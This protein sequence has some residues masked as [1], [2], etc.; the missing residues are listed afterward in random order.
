MLEAGGVK[1]GPY[2]TGSVYQGDCLELMKAIPDGSIP[3]IWTDPPYGMNQND[4]DL[5]NRRE[6]AF[7]GQTLAKH[8]ESDCARP[9][10]N[11]GAEDMERVIRGMLTEAGRVLNRDCCC[12]CCCCSGGGG[13]T[14]MFAKVAMWLDEPPLEFFHAVVWDKGGLGLGMRYRRN[15]EFVMVAKRRGGTLLWAYEGSDM[16]TANVAR[17][18][19]IIPQKNDHPTP[20]PPELVRHF[21]EL[22]TKPGDLVLDPFAGAG[23]TGV[24]CAQMGREFLGFELDPHWVE[25]GNERISAAARGLKVGELRAGQATFGWL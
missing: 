20:K 7:Q 18:P 9:I 5:A 11:D 8:E 6:A 14:P 25:V 24:A 10:L 21:L 16:K 15:Y 4:G 13:P 22:H 1:V 19:K 2:E 3:M 17:I 12:C 23:T